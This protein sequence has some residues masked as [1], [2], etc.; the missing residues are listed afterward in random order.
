MVQLNDYV[1][2]YNRKANM[3]YEQSLSL[4]QRRRPVVDPIPAFREQLMKYEKECR[5]WGYLT[6]VEV[7]E[8]KKQTLTNDARTG[9]QVNSSPAEK[10]KVDAVEE[11]NGP[12]EIK[13]SRVVGP[14][15]PPQKP[16]SIGAAA[17]PTLGASVGP[18][19][20]KSASIGPSIKPTVG[21]S[22]APSDRKSESL[23][24]TITNH[25]DNIDIKSNVVEEKRRIGPEMPPPS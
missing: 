23:G 7:D 5:E 17:K 18:S 25:S 20:N 24:L 4:C 9:V 14:M 22:N 15:P 12:K 8:V 1:E 3:T 11:A 19:P 10:R 16:I 6:A 13:K 21:P 2:K